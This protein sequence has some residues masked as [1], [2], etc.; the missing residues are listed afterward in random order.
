[1]ERFY[2]KSLVRFG[3]LYKSSIIGTAVTVWEIA[4]FATR[5]VSDSP[6]PPPPHREVQTPTTVTQV[7]GSLTVKNVSSVFRHRPKLFSQRS[8]SQ[9]QAEVDTPM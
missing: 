6:L 3:A 4:S 9:E 8:R 5:P 1:M 2:M 7:S